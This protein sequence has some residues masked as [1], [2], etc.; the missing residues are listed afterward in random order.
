M[1]PMRLAKVRPVQGLSHCAKV[2][3]RRRDLIGV[4][5]G[6]A[7]LRPCCALAEGRTPTVAFVSLTSTRNAAFDAFRDELRALGYVEDRSIRL[8]TR[9]LDGKEELLPDALAELV[10]QRVDVIVTEGRSPLRLPGGQRR[11][12]P[13]SW[14]PSET[15][16]NSCRIL[17]TLA[18]TSPDYRCSRTTRM[19][20]W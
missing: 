5:A 19:R 13:S 14:H 17:R 20:S 1:L 18:V 8:A 11:K 6:G 3:V 16:G 9:F 15:H 4:L 12:F 7:I 2:G 10:R